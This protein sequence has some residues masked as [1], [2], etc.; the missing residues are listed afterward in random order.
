VELIGPFCRRSG[1]GAARPP[2]DERG[3][4][5][6]DG[7]ERRA[8]DAGQKSGRPG[9]P[10]QDEQR[11]QEQEDRGAVGEH[12]RRVGQF[13]SMQFLV[14]AVGYFYAQLTP[15]RGSAP[16][17]GP[18]ESQVIGIGPQV[19]FIFPTGSTQ[20]YLSLKAYGEFDGHDRPSGWNAW[21]TL[22][23]SPSAQPPGSAHS[24]PLV[25]KVSM[26]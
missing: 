15:D 11:R 9:D 25:G 5:P 22:S 14:G 12:G 4:Q 18:V 3:R 6:R 1:I 10:R 21:V 19:G 13:L 24:V 8:R 2:H 17:L 20:T 7:A 23:F 26:Q 16:I